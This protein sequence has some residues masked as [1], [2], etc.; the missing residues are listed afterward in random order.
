MEKFF[1]S[2]A[3]ERVNTITFDIFGTV[4]NLSGSI[5]PRLEKLIRSCNAPTSIKGSDVWSHWRQRQRI[6]Q[7]QDNLLMLGHDGYLA[8]K[9]KSLIYILR[10]LK[11]EYNDEQIEEFMG[12]Y[13][14]LNPFEDAVNVLYRLGKKYKLVILSN[15]EKK[16]LKHLA[17]N[18]IGIDFHD[19]FS[20]E[21]VGKF[22]PHPSVYRFAS[23][24]LGIEPHEIMMVASH[25]FDIL[26]ARHSGYRAAYINRYDLPYD[27]S[28]FKPDII[29]EDFNQL[30]IK[31]NV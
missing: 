26:G 22:K 30:C 9:R 14:E 2:N 20:A 15:G 10:T 7:Y 3:L 13:Q 8:I 6:E 1:E 24:N 16:F 28:V 21:T 27:Q 12:V 17:E 18:R 19:I 25:A 4:L 29:T 5:V 23:M 31:L 11:V